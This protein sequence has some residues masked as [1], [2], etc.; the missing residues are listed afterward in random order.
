M[1]MVDEAGRDQPDLIVLPEVFVDLGCS[2]WDYDAL[3]EEVPGPLFDTVAARAKQYG[4]YICCPMVHREGGHVYNAV[5]LIDRKGEP[6]GEYTKYYPTI[7][8]MDGGIAPGQN[9]PVF[10]TDFGRLG[11]AICFDLNFWDVGHALKAAGSEII[12]FC[13][14]YR[15]GFQLRAWAYVLRQFIV[16]ATPRENS[17]IIDPLGR[18]LAESSDY[19][20]I[21]SQR[22]N[23]DTEVVHIDFNQE[24]VRKA[25]AKYGNRLDLVVHSPEAMYMLTSR[26]PKVTVDQMLDE[27]GLERLDAYYERA[28][29]HRA[30]CLTKSARS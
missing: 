21:I 6:I 1:A 26:H 29:K 25:K 7:W 11:I 30:S 24:G 20:R 18:V 12:A 23:L 15:G 14:M 13:S 3:A 17:M 22:I 9:V 5:V 2:K 4:C 27:F 19:G 16:S 10:T 28:R 8:E